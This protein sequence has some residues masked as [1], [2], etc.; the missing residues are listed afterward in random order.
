MEGTEIVGGGR[1][2]IH[3]EETTKLGGDKKNDTQECSRYLVEK[4][5]QRDFKN[6]GNAMIKRLKKDSKA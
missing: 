4:Y 1:K 2:H 3:K 6:A 5:P